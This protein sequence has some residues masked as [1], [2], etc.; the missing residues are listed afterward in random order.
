MVVNPSDE[1][2]EAQRQES[3]DEHNRGQAD[4]GSADF[5]DRVIHNTVGFIG[6][7]EE[8][9]KGYDNGTKDRFPF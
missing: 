1:N 5:V 6:H 9:N 2:E 3:I 8:Y 4:G 7:T